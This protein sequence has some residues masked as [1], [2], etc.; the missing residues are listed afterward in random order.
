MFNF[1]FLLPIVKTVYEVAKPGL[2]IAKDVAVAGI[3]IGVTVK[4]AKLIGKGLDGVR[5]I[6]GYEDNIFQEEQ[7]TVEAPARKAKR[8]AKPKAKKG[9]VAKA[10]GNRSAKQLAGDKKRKATAKKKKAAAL[11]VGEKSTKV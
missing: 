3:A 6:V 11:K 9:N 1:S 7:P 2:N 4:S 10:S 5:H 8:K